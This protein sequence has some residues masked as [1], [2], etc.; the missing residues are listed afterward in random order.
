MKTTFTALILAVFFSLATLQAQDIF[1]L[2]DNGTQDSIATI[3]FDAG[4][5]VEIGGPYWQFTDQDISEFS[6][7][8]LLNGVAWTSSVPQVG[9]DNLRQYISAGGA[10][11]STEWISWSGST[12]QTLNSIIPVSY[13]GSWSTGIETYTVET[14][15]PITENLPESFAV[16]PNWSFSVTNRDENPTLNAITLLKGSRSNDA[17]VIGEFGNGNIVHWNMGGHY[18]GRN[19]W[20]DEVRQILIN[21]AQHLVPGTRVMLESPENHSDDVSQSPEFSWRAIEGAAYYEFQLSTD[22]EL[23]DFIANNMYNNNEPVVLP[24]ELEP[25]TTYYWRVRGSIDGEWGDWSRTWTFTTEFLSNV[26]NPDVI[27]EYKLYSNYPN[28]FNPTTLIEYA[29]PEAEMVRLEVFNT[30]GQRIAVLVNEQQ[31]SGRHTVTFD[32]SNLSSGLYIYRMQA[33]NFVQTR[34]MILVK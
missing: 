13:G 8:I 24:D 9:Q 33:G 18:S 34:K 7:V 27:T 11:L 2:H 19:I 20:S 14:D 16:L 31:S 30:M 12:N 6:L 10:M 21:I 29:L 5:F 28:P 23:N 22:P 15:H 17:L 4:M 1:I 26:E 32:A 3:L 25:G